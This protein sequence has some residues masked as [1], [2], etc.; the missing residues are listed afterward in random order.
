MNGRTQGGFTLIELLVV[1]TVAGLLAVFGAN[2]TLGVL[3]N[4]RRTETGKRL[5]AI[6][7]ALT[8]F[9][10]QNR[11]LPCPAD[12]TIIDGAANDGTAQPV[13]PG[14]C[15]AQ[16]TGVVPW[17]TL[18]LPQSAAF[19]AWNRKFT[20]RVYDDATNG[21]T[22][23]N[24]LDMSACDPAGTAP[25]AASNCAA[26]TPRNTPAQYV[27]NKG[28]IVLT[29]AAGTVLNDPT[30]STPGGAA[31]VLISHGANGRG[32]YLPRPTA[33][34]AA[35]DILF[36]G[37]G[38][39][40]ADEVPNLNGVALNADRPTGSNGFVTRQLDETAATYFD[41]LVRRPTVLAVATAAKLGPRAYDDP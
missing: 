37:T 2:I 22:R 27:L 29:G 32:A 28:L 41:D 9:T 13:G 5:D 7:E 8:L 1:L 33:A 30:N 3:E 19:D 21:L 20:Y 26:A 23:L 4:S 17:V 35:S 12:G 38:V 18:G 14:T 10:A 24:G 25:V 40:S 6:E 11:R 16:T 34:V 15:T 39:T 36:V 31:Y